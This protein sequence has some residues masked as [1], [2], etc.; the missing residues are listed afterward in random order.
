M[1]NAS[2]ASARWARVRAMMA[3]RELDAV[4][5]VDLSRDEILRGNSR[6]L[7]GY[8]PIGGPAAA[9]LHHDGQVELMSERIGQPVR[10]YYRAHDIAV[11]PV[12][13]FSAALVAER[14]GRSG[15][16]RVGIAEAETLPAALA[17]ALAALPSAPALVDVSAEFERLRLRKSAHEVALIRRSCAIADSVW[18]RVPEVFRVGR[19]TYEVL[20]DIDHMVRLEGAEGGFHLIL[21]VPF[22]GR[23]MQSLALGDRVEANARYLLEVSPRLDGYYSQLTIP[24]TTHPHDEAALRAYDDLVAAK[25]AAAPQMKPG[26][27]L[28]EIAKLVAAFLAERG[29]ALTSL[30]MGH[31]CGLALEEPRHD[32]KRPFLLE[33][34]MTLIFHPIL[35]DPELRSLMRADTYLITS[36]GAEK[37]T[38]YEGG[39]LTAS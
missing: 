37:L 25:Q 32:P 33:E 5:A 36:D 1:F 10:E 31:F 23:S 20:A 12:D 29:R 13:G 16:R 4:L 9:L 14:V 35:A 34:G 7:T 26:A 21:P 24:V 22:L 6:W 38:R 15:C 18:R 19:R 8:I 17:A 2:E 28:S 3:T 39:V 30:S 27:D 11:T